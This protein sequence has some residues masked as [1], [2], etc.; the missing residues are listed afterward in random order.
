MPRHP[1]CPAGR[2][3]RLAG[4]LVTHESKRYRLLT[5][6][7][8]RGEVK[9]VLAFLD[10]MHV[11]YSAVFPDP[12]VREC[13]RPTVRVFASKR[14]YAAY[15]GADTEVA[16][17]ANWRGY[18][19]RDRHELVSYRGDTLGELFSILSHEGFHQFAR[20]YIHHPD[21]DSLPDWFEE[22]LADYFRTTRLR[23]RKL[24]LERKVGHLQRVNRAIREGWV[25]T[26]EQ[27]LRCDP[28][29]VTDP[30]AFDAFYAHACMFVEFLI[31]RDKKALIRIYQRKRA[32]VA[33]AAIME[34]LFGKADA[35][36]VYAAFLDHCR[37][38]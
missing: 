32:G 16:F 29:K 34:E 3:R 25:W 33:T 13:P 2:G 6:L 14:D 10:A 35:Q 17:N 24:A 9:K 31:V 18:F 21:A 30:D 23:G 4:E 26:L 15:G 37:R 11:S 19:C 5:D 22:G 38:G 27:I 8:D 12:P 20:E 28:A 7:S 1:R 36:R